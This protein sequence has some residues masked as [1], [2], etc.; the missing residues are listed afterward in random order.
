MTAKAFLKQAY[1]LDERIDSKLEQISAL[2]S[3]TTKATT[4]LRDGP[5]SSTPYVHSRENIIVKLIDLEDEINRDI[6]V[7]IELKT[8]IGRIIKEVG[9]MDY[10][11][12]LEQR[13]LC[14]KPWE[15]IA[16]NMGYSQQ[17]IFR[18]HEKALN[19]VNISGDESPCDCMRI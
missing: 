4:V 1:R 16:D 15:E 17:H 6:D 13:Y 3:L 11:I 8:R 14:F 7:L 5:N 9:H 18:L 10:K 12:L 19:S 2:R